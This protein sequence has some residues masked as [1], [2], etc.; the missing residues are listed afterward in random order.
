M[1]FACIAFALL[2]TVGALV[3]FNDPDPRLWILAYASAAAL[4]AAAALGHS[5]R[6][7]NVAAAIVFGVWFLS[8][9][10]R[11]GPAPKEAFTSFRMQAESHEEPREAAGLALL[12]GWSAVLAYRGRPAREALAETKDV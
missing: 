12:A 4:S 1:K 3:Q 6:G 2:F 5:L 10:T 8:L 11:L 7:P 9:A